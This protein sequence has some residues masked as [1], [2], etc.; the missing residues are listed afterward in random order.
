MKAKKSVKRAIRLPR[1]NAGYATLADFFETHDGADLLSQ[2]L[3]VVEKDRSDLDRM[4]LR[5]WKE[6]NT[7][8]LNIR[9]PATAKRMIERLARRKTVETST[10]VRMWVMDGMRREA[11]GR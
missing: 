6:P 10:L 2:G 7:R 8:Q 4:L 3:T 1:A 9:I 5:Y 11:L